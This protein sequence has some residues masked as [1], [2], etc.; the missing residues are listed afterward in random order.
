M[1]RVIEFIPDELNEIVDYQEIGNAIDQYHANKI[2][3]LQ[4]LKLNQDILSADEKTI[5]K[6]EQRMGIIP[7]SGETLDER[8]YRCWIHQT[9]HTPFTEQWLRHWLKDFI[10]EENYRL[11][12]NYEART[13]L[14]KLSLSNAVNYE[15]VAA[16]LDEVVPTKIMYVISYLFNDWQEVYD[17]YNWESISQWT[18][19]DVYSNDSF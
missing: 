16:L 5:A 12:F 10:G 3:Q 1:K 17:K 2:A 14:L 11:D 7:K 15:S 9:T 18:W 4:Q 6:L 19:E 8:R 13:F